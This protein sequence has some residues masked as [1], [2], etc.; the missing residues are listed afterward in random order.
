MSLLEAMAAGVPVGASAV[1]GIPD[2]VKHGVNGLLVAPRDSIDLL[3]ALRRLL[4]EPALAARL[5]AAGRETVRAR[6]SPEEV[7]ERLDG[8]YAGLG[9]AR[10]VPEVRRGH[11]RRVA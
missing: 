2:V 9:V 4:R 8:V 5:G 7:L 6:F 11:L 1:G 10:A 3:R